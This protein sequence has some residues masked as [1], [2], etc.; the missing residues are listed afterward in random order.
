MLEDCTTKETS[1]LF[2]NGL[3]KGMILLCFKRTKQDH[4]NFLMN[5]ALLERIII[6]RICERK[7]TVTVGPSCIS[8]RYTQ[9]SLI[10][11]LY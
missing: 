8:H 4:N 7:L 2:I 1:V 10:T 3:I 11:S 9:S 5:A 6:L